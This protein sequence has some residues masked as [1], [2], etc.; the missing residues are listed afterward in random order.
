MNLLTQESTSD[1]NGIVPSSVTLSNPAT[2]CEWYKDFLPLHSAKCEIIHFNDVYD[3]EGK[4][5]KD[6]DQNTI[7]GGAARFKT[8]LDQYNSQG[9]LVIFSGDLFFPS[10]LSNYFEGQ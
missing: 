1:S 3:L 9:K 8:A 4:S 7:L 6:C 2:K 10:I 5:T